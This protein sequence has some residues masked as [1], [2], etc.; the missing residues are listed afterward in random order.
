MYAA[1]GARL[2]SSQGASVVDRKDVVASPRWMLSLSSTSQICSSATPASQSCQLAF[3]FESKAQRI[4]MRREIFVYISLPWRQRSRRCPCHP[5]STLGTP[6]PIFIYLG[7]RSA[8]SLIAL[9]NVGQRSEV[10]TSD[11]APTYDDCT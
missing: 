11:R 3:Y 1:S 2:G 10:V 6:R 9:L 7:R 8:R 4:G 5:W